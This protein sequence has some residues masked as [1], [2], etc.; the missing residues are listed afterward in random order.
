MYELH[1]MAIPLFDHHPPPFYAIDL[2]HLIR[3]AGLKASLE[4][5]C[6]FL[7]AVCPIPL[8]SPRAFLVDLRVVCVVLGSLL[9]KA[10]LQYLRILNIIGS[11]TV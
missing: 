2:M 3:E 9:F 11:R 6:W 5:A 8:Q 4:L 7:D 10:E 1:G